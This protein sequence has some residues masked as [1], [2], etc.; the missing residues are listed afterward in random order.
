[1][2]DVY[3]KKTIDLELVKYQLNNGLIDLL[4]Q[5]NLR[6]LKNHLIF[7]CAFSEFYRKYKLERGCVHL[8]PSKIK[9]KTLGFLT[10]IFYCFF[11]IRWD[12][13][14]QPYINVFNI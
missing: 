13:T 1:M 12:Y 11:N 2:Y 7:S 10:G 14:H 5:T 3:F 6:V 9:S 8:F 4:F